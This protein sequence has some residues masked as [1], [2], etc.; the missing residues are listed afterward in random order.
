M[1]YN[2]TF[3][4]FRYLVLLVIFGLLSSA[5]LQAQGLNANTT[6][7]VNG[8]QDLAAPVDTFANLTG[9]ITGPS[10][11]ALT[12]LN[13]YGMNST[14]TQTGQVTFLLSASSLY[15]YFHMDRAIEKPR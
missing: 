5:R 6:Y 3:N 7:V 11:G 12:Y 9:T 8:A 15:P 2:Y 14:Q 13:Q 1:K 10:Y 4:V